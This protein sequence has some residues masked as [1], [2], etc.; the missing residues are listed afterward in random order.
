M[1]Y[2]T[3]GQGPPLL[4]IHG[5][6]AS[7]RSFLLPASRLAA[8]FRCIAYDQPTGRG[9]GARLRGY[10]HAHLVEDVWALL[11]HLGV[12]RS[13]VLG[14]SFGGTIALAALHARPERLPRA[15]L[16]GGFA[17]RPLSGVETVLAGLTRWL[18]GSV[19]QLPLW[20]RATRAVHQPSFA[21][22]PAERW[23]Y[24]LECSG[25]LPIASFAHQALLLHRLDVRP[26][27]AGV[28]QPVLLV[29]GDRDP[30]IGRAHEE[31]LLAGL[32]SAGRVVLE[33]CGHVPC[34]THPEA[35]AEVTRQFLTPSP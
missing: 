7:S 19:A 18:P 30:V 31:T 24:Y 6:T 12:T 5:V 35:L 13:Y 9:D 28:R 16:Q 15:V 14:S 32:P 25:R 4:L 34:H 2:Y 11:D 10:T 8:Q 23:P 17:H 29:C 20:A 3:W 1:P 22:L 21:G 27:L 26:L 33:G